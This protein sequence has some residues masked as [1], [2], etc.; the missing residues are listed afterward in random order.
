MF[1]R[2]L[3]ANVAYAIG[4]LAGSTALFLLT[5]YLVNALSPA[6]YGRWILFEI[7]LLILNVVM[8]AGL[9]VG[10]M[11]EYWYQESEED[12]AR[13]AGT[14]AA[15]VGLWGCVLLLVG[16]A[17]NVV[18]RIDPSLGM[19]LAVGATESVF[20]IYQTLFRIREHAVTFVALSV[21]RVVLFLAVA[22][23]LI[24]LGEGA[25][26]V[27]EARLAASVLM[28]GAAIFLGRRYV[29]RAFDPRA[30]RRALVYGLPLLPTN[31]A[32]YVL[33]GS[34]RYF[35]QYFA[36]LQTVAVY[37]FAYK[38]ATA[39][40]V[41]VTRPFATDWAPRRFRLAV[42]PNAPR[43]YA[44]VAAVYSAVALGFALVIWAL[45]PAAYAVLAPDSYAAGANVVPVLLLAYVI[46]GLS[47][48]MN[49]GIMLRDRTY[50]LPLLGAIA[51]I[52]CVGLSLWWIPVQG[53]LG[54]AWATVV[55]YAVWTGGIAWASLRVYPVPYDRRLLGWVW[56]S[57][58]LGAVGL[59]VLPTAPTSNL[60]PLSNIVVAELPRMLLVGAVLIVGAAGTFRSF[61]G[62]RPM[63][64]IRSD[65]VDVGS[66]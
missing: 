25:N 15:A 17:V 31:L 50:L 42:R 53:M 27:L 39:L 59:Y 3:R 43:H 9:D 48:P 12:R 46:Y 2:L 60:D 64:A 7:D 41:A 38:L 11:R 55:A 66:V 35:L 58:A 5:P 33:F 61:I 49:V 51:V 6:E 57:A 62:R 56:M 32:S 52:V 19:L 34:D 20:A 10:L 63:A 22:I 14:I 21:G 24:Y 37:S 13:L 1:A 36:G 26:G 29:S 65:D 18:L 28:L 54:A 16:T 8:Q 40:D 45:A 4:S 44:N 23:R 47:Y 30:L